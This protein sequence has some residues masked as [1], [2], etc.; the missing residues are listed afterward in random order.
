MTTKNSKHA[1][2]LNTQLNAEETPNETS[3]RELRHYEKIQG[4]PFTLVRDGINWLIVMGNH[5]VTD[6]C[7]TREIALNKLKQDRWDII[8]TMILIVQNTTKE[9]QQED[10]HK[11]ENS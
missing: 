4:T 7:D 1:D 8:L 9:Q 3:S 2:I 5:R 11:Y 6:N 10:P